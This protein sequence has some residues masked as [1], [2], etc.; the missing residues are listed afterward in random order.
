MYFH[1]WT[2]R[3]LGS[4]SSNTAV[5]IVSIMPSVVF[6]LSVYK[7]KNICR[8]VVF[9]L[10]VHSFCNKFGTRCLWCYSEC[11]STPSD[12]RVTSQASY[13]PE[14]ITPTQKISSLE[15]AINNLWQAWWHCQTCYKLFWKVWYMQ[16]WYKKNVARL[17]TQGCNNIVISLL[18]RTCWNNIATNLIISTRL[19]QV[20]YSLFQTCW[21]HTTCWRLVGRLNTTCEIFTCA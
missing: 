10:L 13:S 18:Y 1:T 20:C 14:Y 7:R 11:I 3:S 2:F 12:I 16:S 19:F 17:T 15:Q 4:F 9:A 8:Q 6:C 5:N 21:Q